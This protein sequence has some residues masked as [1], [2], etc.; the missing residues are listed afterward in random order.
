ML[1]NRVLDICNTGEVC[2]LDNYISKQPIEDMQKEWKDNQQIKEPSLKRAIKPVLFCMAL[3]G[4]YNFSD[5]SNASNTGRKRKTLTRV[6]SLVY[7]I[8]IL[9]VILLIMARF[10]SVF[11]FLPEFKMWAINVLMWTLYLTTCWWVCFKQTSRRYGHYEQVMRL[12]DD[13]VMPECKA[14][15]IDLC[16]HVIRKRVLICSVVGLIIVVVSVLLNVA[17]MRITLSVFYVVPFE[18]TVEQQLLTTFGYIVTSMVWIIPVVA[19]ITLTRTLTFVF[20]AFNEH[21]AKQINDDKTRVP[22]NFK[23]MRVLHL[24]ICQLLEEMDGDLKWFFASSF[25]MG[26]GGAVFTLYQIMRTSLDTVGLVML[27]F[28]I[29]AG[30]TNLGT[31]AGFAAFTHEAVSCDIICLLHNLCNLLHK[32]CCRWFYLNRS[33]R[34]R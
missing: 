25:L 8:L 14:L 30:L 16:E 27:I 23:R 15:G 1:S 28:W 10:V 21:F 18:F 32:T 13:V 2:E 9:L 6:F 5:I 12:W 7:R 31:G 24:R 17:H 33:S 4:C 3:S 29:L 34:V 11:Y 19:A 22:A 20:N 26:I